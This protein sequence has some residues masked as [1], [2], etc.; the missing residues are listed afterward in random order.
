[1]S[2]LRFFSTLFFC[3]A[4]FGGAPV[5]GTDYFVAIDGNDD[6]PGTRQQPWRTIQKAA[7][8]MIA[9]D[10]VFI[11]QGLYV[12]RVQ[13]QNPGNENNYIT[14]QA[15]PGEEVVIESPNTWSSDFCFYLSDSRDLHHL[16]FIGLTLRNASGANIYV[17]AGYSSPKSFIVLDG[18]TIESGYLGVF[19]RNGVTESLIVN[20]EIRENQY[21]IYLDRRNRDILIAEN[22]VSYTQIIDP[23]DP[24]SNNI[25][26]YGVQDSENSDI[27]IRDNHVHHA[28]MQG[29]EVFHAND[30]LIKNNHCH[31]NGAT[32]IQIEGSGGSAVSDRVVVDG[33][34]CEYNSQTYQSETGMWIDDSQHVIVQNNTSRHNEIGLKITGS[35]RVIVRYNTIYM[36]NH[37]TFINSSGIQVRESSSDGKS[38]DDIIV[39]N[40]F[41]RNGQNSQRA[42][43]VVGVWSHLPEVERTVF[44][45]NISADSLADIDLWIVGLTHTLDNNNYYNSLRELSVRWQGSIVNWYTYILTS[46]QDGYSISSDPRFIDPGKGLF[47]LMTDSPCRDAGGPLTTTTSNGSGTEV[48]VADARYFS[49]GMGVIEGDRIRIGANRI[50]IVLGVDYETNMITV[51]RDLQW[52][53]GDNVNYPY[54]GGAPDMGAFE[55]GPRVRKWLED[56]PDSV[57]ELQIEGRGK[58]TYQE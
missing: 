6:N 44:R 16:R 36:N 23:V 29:I 40:T 42:Q 47:K 18:L 45:N 54:H 13:P 56:E 33:N 39:H 57:N 53:T 5:L 48:E 12:E 3:V 51:D 30:I 46:G 7:N 25:N 10:H 37:S 20:C 49:D 8:T 26:L 11:R 55:L 52:N 4:L 15:Y 1:M 19:F 27:I 17:H 14:Y 34:L 22:E 2:T 43:A 41:Y 50:A 9:G 32:G 38:T 31:H 21:N 28:L 58:R 24:W 35:T